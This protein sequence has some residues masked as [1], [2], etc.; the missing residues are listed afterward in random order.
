MDETIIE[1]IQKLLALSTSTNE[2][3]A[4]VALAKAQKMLLLVRDEELK[5]AVQTFFPKVK[6]A[7]TKRYQMNSGYSQGRQ[8]GHQVRFRQEIQ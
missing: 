4:A 1:K 2:H 7:R 3:E 8:A 6:K 5:K